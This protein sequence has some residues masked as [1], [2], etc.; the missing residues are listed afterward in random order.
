MG[1]RQVALGLAW[2]TVGAAA[3]VNGGTELL[4][5]V[6]AAAV[7]VNQVP[8]VWAALRED[9]LSGLAPATW[10]FAL[11]DGALWGGYGLAAGDR[12]VVLYGV[13]LISAACVILTRLARTRSLRPSFA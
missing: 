3:W 7:L 6:L 4:G 9:D 2:A 12:A 5:L 10:L 1:R 11:A 13:I 8:Q